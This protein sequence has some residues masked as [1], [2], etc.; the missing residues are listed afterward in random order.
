MKR[1]I[2]IGSAIILLAGWVLAQAQPQGGGGGGGGGEFTPPTF[3]A[4]NTETDET[5]DH[6]T[7]AE[8]MAFM[9]QRMAALGGRAGGPGPGPGAGP[10]PG[11]GAGPGPGPRGGGPG[12]MFRLWDGDGDGLVSREEFQGR[13]LGGFGGPAGGGPRGGGPGG[14]NRGP[15]GPDAGG[16]ADQ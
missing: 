9:R 7:E 10:G 13:Q 2:T 15:G 1:Q 3:D 16:A 5:P 12:G 4:M 6:L 14:G 11:P 8:V